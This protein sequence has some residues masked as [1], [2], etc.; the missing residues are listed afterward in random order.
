[1]ENYEKHMVE[2]Q[3]FQ[4]ELL[5]FE[6]AGVCAILLSGSVDTHAVPQLHDKVKAVAAGQRYN[7]IVD[8]DGVTYISSTGLGFLMYLY[9]QKREFIYLSNPRAAILKP[10]NLIDIKNL[11]HY[12]HL[13]D[14]LKRQT[15]MPDDAITSI[16]EQKKTLRAMKPRK[17]GLEILAD[18][19]DNENELYEIRRMT[20]Y[21][22]AAEHQDTFLLPAEEKYASVL[23]VFLDR[24]FGR[25]KD[26]SGEPINEGTVELVAKELMTNAVKHGYGHQPGGMVEV[27]YQAD[28]KKVEITFTD[29]GKGCL[30]GVG[31]EDG[32][33]PM[34]L[35]ILRKIFDE[36]TISDA[37]RT[38]AAGLVLGPGTTVRMVKY[39][40]PNTSP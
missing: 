5:V 40:K 25:A 22:H 2:T 37:P 15:G 32:L 9:K 27:G 13:V 17:R 31:K 39:L 28:R 36:L 12:Y 10:F 16:M 6:G 33:P 24:V 4:G 3:N 26:Y 21:I 30:P 35:D 14:E 29:H 20:P 19:L 34:G 8:L 1:M 38:K 7:Y 18:Y 11:F 23:Y